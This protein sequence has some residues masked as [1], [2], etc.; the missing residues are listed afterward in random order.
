MG[1]FVNSASA[2]AF[3]LE[4]PVAPASRHEPLLAHFPGLDTL[5]AAAILMV[6]SRHARELLGGEFF[7]PIL[8]P[9]F[10]AGWIGVDLFFVLSG[11]L[12]GS[13]L[14]Q[15]VRRDG[16]V[17]FGRFYFKRSLRIIPGHSCRSR[18]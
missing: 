9:I 6:I 14:I 5:K 7:G 2:T 1:N 17:R 3:P 16:Q 11:F 13:Q 10:N 8:K 4:G 15:A 18:A 12:I